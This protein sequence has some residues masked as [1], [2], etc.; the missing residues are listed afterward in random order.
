MRLYLM[1]H[2][3]AR[4]GETDAEKSL[5]EEGREQVERV[6]TFLAGSAPS[7]H[8]RVLHSGKTRARESAEILAGHFTHLDA[9]PADALAPMDDPAVWAERAR[10][11]NEAVAL[12]GHLPHLERLTALLLTGDADRPVVRFVHGGVVCLDRDLE[13]RWR[14]AWSVVPSLLGLP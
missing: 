10:G 11:L 7:R 6:A 12:V 9:E 2:G 14:L 5:T 8:G 3:L 13:G 1:Q 4:P